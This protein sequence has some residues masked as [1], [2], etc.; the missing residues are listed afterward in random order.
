[1][2]LLKYV[3]VFGYSHIILMTIS[4]FCYLY[5][6]IITDP[7]DF[8]WLDSKTGELKTAKP[9]DRE[10]LADPSSPLNLTVRVSFFKI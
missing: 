6:F 8:F 5:L 2:I 4:Y 1:M 7:L 9:L 10:A 3:L